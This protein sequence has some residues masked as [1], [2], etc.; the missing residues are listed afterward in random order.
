MTR[1]QTRGKINFAFTAIG[2]AI[3][4]VLIVA[5]G[6]KEGK[7]VVPT[8]CD[9]VTE[10]DA[11]LFFGVGPGQLPFQYPSFYAGCGQTGP[12]FSPH[13]TANSV[14]NQ[15]QLNSSS[16]NNYFCTILVTA[17]CPAGS[18]YTKQYYWQAGS[19]MNIKILKNT[20][21]SIEVKYIDG[22]NICNSTGF[23]RRTV[24]MGSY[25]NSS[26]GISDNIVVTPTWSGLY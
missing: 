14:T 12:Y 1:K 10:M 11:T 16:P 23:P 3:L 15:A 13:Q 21:V 22:L 2:G 6:L 20:P 24:W 5:G 8:E 4:Y 18:S 9:Q 25:N 17:I 26:I 19:T 7:I